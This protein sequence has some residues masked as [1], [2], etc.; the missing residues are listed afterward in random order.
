MQWRNVFYQPKN[1]EKTKNNNE[2]K[3][4]INK[5]RLLTLSMADEYLLFLF[6]A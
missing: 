2:K 3:K 6:F 4:Q 5:M 1:P